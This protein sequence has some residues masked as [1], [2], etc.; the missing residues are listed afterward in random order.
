MVTP[1]HRPT[2]GKGVPF[3]GTNEHNGPGAM[4]RLAGTRTRGHD[5]S[6][7]HHGRPSVLHSLPGA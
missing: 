2:K 7:Q 6:G 1:S 5:R 3:R 4:A